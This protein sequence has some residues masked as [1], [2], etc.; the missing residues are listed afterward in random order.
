MHIFL[1]TLPASMSEKRPPYKRCKWCG[2]KKVAPEK[3]LTGWISIYKKDICDTCLSLEY[4]EFENVRTKKKRLIK[5]D[6]EAEDLLPLMMIDDAKKKTKLYSDLRSLRKD[7]E[8]FSE[9]YR[10]SRIRIIDRQYHNLNDSFL[11]YALDNEG[12]TTYERRSLHDWRGCNPR[13]L[14]TK[15]YYHALIARGCSNNCLSYSLW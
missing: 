4:D 3:G 1:K 5:S 13:R 11:S 12:K 9:E 2:R 14:V 7:L 8:K 10:K 6:K 15:T